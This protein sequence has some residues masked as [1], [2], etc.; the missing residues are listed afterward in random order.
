MT[1]AKRRQLGRLKNKTTPGTITGT[2]RGRQNTDMERY[3]VKRRCKYSDFFYLRLS[4]SL[5]PDA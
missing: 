2:G 4:F 1:Q 5:Y 3:E